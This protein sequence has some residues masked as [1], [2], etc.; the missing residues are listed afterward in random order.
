MN[1]LLALYKEALNKIDNID[2]SCLIYLTIAQLYGN[3][4]Q[5]EICIRPMTLF[6]EICIRVIQTI[7]IDDDLVV[8]YKRVHLGQD[9]SDWVSKFRSNN[10]TQWK[11]TRVSTKLVSPLEQ[12][13]ISN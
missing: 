4:V 13:T 12:Q 11:L 7:K 9:A 2:V 3:Y 1:R 5:Q 10:T 8:Y 6:G